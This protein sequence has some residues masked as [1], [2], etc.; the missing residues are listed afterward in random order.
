MADTTKFKPNT[1]FVTYIAAT[2]DKVWQAL[3]DPA[4]TKAYFFGHAIEIEPKPGGS[5][6]LRM[7]DGRAGWP[8]ILSSLKSL[9]ETGRPLSINMAPLKEMIE[10]IKALKAQFAQ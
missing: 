4:F 5:F 6:V 10:A 1:V 3:T 9:L 7:P 8:A 2:P